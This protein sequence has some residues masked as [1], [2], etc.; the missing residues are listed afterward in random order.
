M[1][2]TAAELTSVTTGW[3]KKTPTD[4]TPIL[5]QGEEKAITHLFGL[6]L[7]GDTTQEGKQLRWGCS[8]S[9]PPHGFICPSVLPSFFLIFTEI[10]EAL[11]N[12]WINIRTR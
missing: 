10:S 11:D 1:L 3:V 5:P 6:T 9:L 8:A 7:V 4:L 12:V 2:A